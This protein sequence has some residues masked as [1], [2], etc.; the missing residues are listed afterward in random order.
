MDLFP[1]PGSAPGDYWSGD[2]IEESTGGLV[3]SGY[4]RALVE[5]RL[6]APLDEAVDAVAGVM[7]VGDGLLYRSVGWWRRVHAE[8]GRGEELARA[9]EAAEEERAEL[10]LSRLANRL[11]DELGGREDF[12]GTDAELAASSRGRLTEEEVGAIRDGRLSRVAD[13]KL[14][15]FCEKPRL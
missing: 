3:T 2:E 15:A 12:T 14:L 9:I 13:L 5:G 6:Y 8:R 7:G 1:P 4:F 11:F 10:R